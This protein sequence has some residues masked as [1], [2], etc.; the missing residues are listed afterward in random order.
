MLNMDNALSSISEYKK[1]L[2]QQSVS[3]TETGKTLA[4]KTIEADKNINAFAHLDAKSVTERASRLEKSGEKGR[5][6][7]VP[8][9]LKDNICV[10]DQDSSLLTTPQSP[11]NCWRKGLCFLE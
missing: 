9:G 4:E 11:K 7:G 10:K 1:W 8:I 2:S 3:F 5:L 6:W